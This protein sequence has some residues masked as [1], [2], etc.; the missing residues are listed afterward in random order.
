MD[1]SRKNPWNYLKKE[2]GRYSSRQTDDLDSEGHILFYFCAPVL[3]GD[4][5]TCHPVLRSLQ[6][7]TII[8]VL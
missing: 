6:V 8:E 4:F 2:D 5:E 7:S 3:P 1:L